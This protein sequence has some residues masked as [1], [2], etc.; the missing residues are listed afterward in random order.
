MD[1][2]RFSEEAAELPPTP[3]DT[4]M[5]VRSLRLPQELD[6]R[7]KAV[8][9]ARRVPMSTLLREWIELELAALEDDQPISRADA[10]RALA[11]LRPLNGAA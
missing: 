7:L 4:V 10:L 9:E 5:V 2:L 8:A 1:G 11:N 3:G 6:R